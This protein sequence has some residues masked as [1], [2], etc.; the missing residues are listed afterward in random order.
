MGGRPAGGWVGGEREGGWMVRG[1][2]GG[3]T[4]IP[5]ITVRMIQMDGGGGV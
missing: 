1:R 5:H 2:E 3:G 4:Y